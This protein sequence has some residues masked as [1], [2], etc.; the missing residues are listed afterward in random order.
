[1][2]RD[3]ERK[4]WWGN[5]ELAEGQAVR[6][7]I[8][9]F[10]LAVQR[11]RQEWR[12]AYD[13]GEGPETETNEWSVDME[14]IAFRELQ[15]QERYVFKSTQGTLAVV[16][17]LAD[18]PVV[19]QPHTPFYVPAAEETTI[20]VSSPLWIRMKVHEPPVVLQEIPIQR[21]SD[22]WFGPS[23]REGELCYAGRTQGRLHRE[24]L[25]IRPHRAY[26]PVLIRNDSQQPML[27]ERLNVPVPYLTVF[28]TRTGALWTE[29]VFMRR[30]HD[31]QRASLNI[32]DRAPDFA[33]GS[34]ALCEP[35]QHLG[36]GVLVRAFGALF[37]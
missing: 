35:R 22:T 33:Q 6:W 3:Q 9:A 30:E 23:T 16:P 32:G 8:G 15:A 36:K 27:L 12:V 19:I 37:G 2:A 10:T 7:S 25:H 13:R 17:A 14:A 24:E 26:T 29:T 21:P 20:Y 28:A 31:G 34:Q 11:L 4:N 18:R 1:M 5:F